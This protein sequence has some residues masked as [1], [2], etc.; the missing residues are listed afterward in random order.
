MYDDEYSVSYDYRDYDDEERDDWEPA[1]VEEFS[2]CEDK[3]AFIEH[4]KKQ[5]QKYGIRK[6]KSEP[7][8]EPK[9]FADG[10]KEY[11][12]SKAGKPISEIYED[13]PDEEQSY[14][15]LQAETDRR[16]IEEYNT[17]E[18]RERVIQEAV[19]FY[20]NIPMYDF[21]LG[22]MSNMHAI[23]DF[24]G[25]DIMYRIQEEIR[26]SCNLPNDVREVGHISKELWQELRDIRAGKKPHP[27]A[28]IKKR[29][30]CEKISEPTKTKKKESKDIEI[31]Q[32]ERQ[33]GDDYYMITERG[34]IRNRTYREL[35][36]GP[37]TVYDWIWANLVRSEW[38]DT[39]GYPIKE[40]YYDKGLLAYCSTPG[41]IGKDCGM[42]KNTA[43]KYIN[44]FKKAG[45]IKVEYLVPKDKKSG[46]SVY[47][48][49][50]WKKV[51]GKV[52]ERFYRDEVFL[53]E[54]MV[55][56]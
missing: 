25:L 18:Y 30:D 29:N 42:S 31:I 54:K 4:V 8:S 46:Q 39:K 41:K 17:P 19:E 40:K 50:T 11:I 35:F 43:K 33:P 12:Q 44:E 56:N 55:K 10:L 37:G 5:T 7:K 1:E 26:E 13:D 21:G 3:E 24:Y 45:I 22:E 15:E 14:A 51:N 36:K 20:S 53:S 34:V 6:W 27:K 38:I 32:R 16:L 47:I 49:G 28:T 48:L 23:S 52:V 9:D 2:Q